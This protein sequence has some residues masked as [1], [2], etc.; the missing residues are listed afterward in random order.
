MNLQIRFNINLDIPTDRGP[1]SREGSTERKEINTK[2]I[3]IGGGLPVSYRIQQTV[4]WL[5]FQL[6]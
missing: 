4:N 3:H 5:L 1:Q 2:L 6:T